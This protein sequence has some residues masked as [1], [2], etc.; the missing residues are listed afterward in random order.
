[1][2]VHQFSPLYSLE[3]N[4]KI[5]EWK[6]VVS[7][8]H[9]KCMVQIQY[10]QKDGKKTMTQ[11]EYTIG[12]NIGKTNETTAWE[13]AIFETTR[14]WKNKKEKENYQETL[15][16]SESHTY[17]PMLAQTYDPNSTVKKK[18][19]IDYPCYVQPK[20]DGVRCIVYLSS[21]S[22]KRVIFQ[23][24]TGS[25]FTSFP[26][27]S[28]ELMPILSASPDLIFDGELFTQCISF[29][30]LVGLVKKK[31][32]GAKENKERE[33]IEYH[34]YDIIENKPYHCRHSTLQ[35]LFEENSLKYIKNVPTYW[36]DD[37]D[38]FYV[39]FTNFINEGQEGIMLRNC[40]GDYKQ[41]Y[42]S[43]DLQK[44][45]EF[46]EDEYTIIGYKEASG[47]DIGTVIWQCQTNGAIAKEFW[48]RPRGRRELRR[49]WFLNGQDYI[50]KK[51]TVIYQELSTEGIPR[52][53]VGKAIREHY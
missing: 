26:H 47:N 25:E 24:R 21:T 40:Q 43:V 23:S 11:K 4:G 49:E 15:C 41:K 38:Q 42:R 29:E 2:S 5:R 1:M 14:K 20:L 31:K 45:K 27:L 46:F 10:G 9:S 52:F 18:K 44:Y 35:G 8:N 36:C 13:Q 39:H 53:P 37:K 50:G 22:P 6:A 7:G 17:Y 34:I 3:K 28:R 19:T 12:K 30:E 32:V 33:Q 16:F 48:V 51:L